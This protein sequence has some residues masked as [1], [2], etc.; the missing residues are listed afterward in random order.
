VKGDISAPL[1]E[2][3]IRYALE[4]GRAEQLRQ[5][6]I[7]LA[8]RELRAPMAA[9]KS[10]AIALLLRDRGELNEHAVEAIGRVIQ[11][12]DHCTR[13]LDGFVDL[14]RIDASRAVRSEPELFDVRGMVDEAVEI[15]RL[16]APERAFHVDVQSAAGE[17]RADRYELLL[18][19]VDVLA[20][21]AAY[22]PS[23]AAVQV[24]VTDDDGVV[25][26]AVAD[27]GPGIPQSV[28]EDLFTPF[29][30][31]KD[32][33]RRGARGTG[34]GLCHGKRVIEAHGGSIRVES[35]VGKGTTVYLELPA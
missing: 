8:S 17:L 27:A 21:A 28:I 6:L 13:L 12:A 15:A 33:L 34:L 4:R 19:L 3:S 26:F 31:M 29:Y 20:N 2:R 16:S 23:G 1:L 11:I 10:E 32:P 7:A 24:V 18:V 14:S 9:V 25:R 35:A 22:S 5:G 30:L